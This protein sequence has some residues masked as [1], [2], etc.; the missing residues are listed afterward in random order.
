MKSETYP[1]TPKLKAIY[2]G[3]KQ[4]AKPSDSDM[5]RGSAAALRASPNWKEATDEACFAMARLLH[6]QAGDK[7]KRLG[8]FNRLGEAPL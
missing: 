2:Q 8:G 3:I 1:W 7:P 5:V 6:A 4:H